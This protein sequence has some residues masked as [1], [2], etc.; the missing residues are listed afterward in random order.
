MQEYLPFFERLLQWASLP[1]CLYGAGGAILHSVR[2]GRS[3]AQVLFEALGGVITA[4][5]I[6]PLIQEWTPERW[7]Y[8]LFFLAGW[9]G[10]EFVGRC[11]EAAVSALEH[12]IRRQI[13][14]RNGE[15]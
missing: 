14:P 11:Y 5:M 15:E 4:N 9:G 3:A 13:N 8:T 10:L 1:A 7:H 12:R 6:C 2:K